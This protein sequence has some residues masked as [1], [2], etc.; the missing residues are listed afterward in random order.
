[1]ISTSNLSVQFGKRV[2]FDE[3]NVT[4]KKGNCYGI[5]G[6]NG[7]GKSTFLKILSGKLN[8]NSGN[9]IIDTNKRLSVLEQ[10]Q[11]EFDDFETLKTTIM[12]NKV[13][14]EIKKEMDDLYS[15]TDFNDEDGVRVG[16][17][18]NRYEEMDG[19]NAESDA[20]SL[21]SQLGVNENLHYTKMSDLEPKTK[22]R[23]LLAQALFGNPDILIMDEPTNNLD[24]ETIKWLQNFLINYENTVIVVSHDR[25]FLDSVCT[26]IS[27]IDY[28]KI[29]H[30]TGNYS[31]WYQSSQLALKQRA[32]QNKKAEDKKKELE[33]FI[34]RFSANVAKSKQATSRKKMIEKLNIEEIKPSSRR[35][36]GIIFE[37]E[38]ESGD[39]ILTI[40]NLNFSSAIND[41]NL[42]LNKGDKL[43]LFSKD[44]KITSS[45]YEIIL[46]NSNQSE[47][48]KWGSTISKSFIPN[49]HDS[50][51]NKDLNLIDWLR[52]W[53]NNDEERKED[54]IRGF[55]GKM[56]FSGDEALKSC[57]V[58]SG[59]EKVR[60]MLSK[61]MMERSNFL[62]F[63]DPTNHLDL[64]TITALN[65]SLI[66]FK[67][68][69]ILTTQDY[70]FANSVGNRVFEIGPKGYIDKLMKFEDYLNDEK[71]KE[72][73]NLI[74]WSLITAS[75]FLLTDFIIFSEILFI[76]LSLKVFSFELNDTENEYDILFFVLSDL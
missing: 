34:S 54:F 72:Q 21:L 25:Y 15:K 22:V 63:D 19:W 30:Y 39:Q 65:N 37:Q 1:M 35:Y 44:S 20:A 45:F 68:N 17:L 31:F 7:S 57:K 13:L 64:E 11:N 60:C 24:F 10:N 53:A 18:Q 32:Q 43:I 41:L 61:T 5:I 42:I 28:G 36:P 51:F 75:C 12:G 46:N 70:E 71:V 67:G 29:S 9:V 23:V 58:L 52:Q 56:I 49:D 4:F 16:E 3:V 76:S 8:P 27:D 38:R 48:I 2:L 62:L 14:Y 50:Y 66:R 74:Y 47:T 73:R 6:A 69:L 26:H 40:E 59:G 33:E 55:L